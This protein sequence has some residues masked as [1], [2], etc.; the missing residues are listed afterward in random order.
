MNALA[1]D[2]LKILRETK[3]LEHMDNEMDEFTED[4]YDE[5]NRPKSFT[6]MVENCL[7]WNS[8]VQ[9]FHF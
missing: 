5:Q 1:A 7:I 2:Y 4:M 3:E 8:A 9:I 6:L